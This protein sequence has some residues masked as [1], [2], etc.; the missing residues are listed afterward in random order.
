VGTDQTSYP[1]EVQVVLNECQSA[2][3]GCPKLKKREATISDEEL[4]L[5][6]AG[7]MDHMITA[8]MGDHRI[9]WESPPQTL[10][11]IRDLVT[12]AQ[13]SKLAT[14]VLIAKDG[15]MIGNRDCTYLPYIHDAKVPR[16]DM[17][18]RFDKDDGF[19][20][21]GW[22]RANPILMYMNAKFCLWKR[23]EYSGCMAHLM[24]EYHDQLECTD[25]L[26]DVSHPPPAKK[27]KRD[28][29]PGPKDIHETG[30]RVES[31]K[32]ALQGWVVD[33]VM[34]LIVAYDGR[35]FWPRVV[36][37]SREG[38]EWVQFRVFP[39][40]KSF[41]NRI[42]SYPELDQRCRKR[43]AAFLSREERKDRALFLDEKPPLVVPFS[44]MIN[45]HIGSEFELIPSKG[46]SDVHKT[47]EFTEGDSWDCFWVSDDENEHE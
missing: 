28:A 13:L 34:P 16:L 18:I 37:E 21:R 19:T 27:R 4:Y 41:M 1:Y 26:S 30:E 6:Y 23:S 42:A 45:P 38:G 8:A 7:R 12:A 47:E 10:P 35:P 29:P 20:D 9:R 11:T 5:D 15:I 3:A 40:Q 14:Y 22:P 31:I 44:G 39:D 36:R 24:T 43:I 33:D 2:L 32:W 17:D 46:A 25:C